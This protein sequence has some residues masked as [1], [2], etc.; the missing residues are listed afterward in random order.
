MAEDQIY[1]RGHMLKTPFVTLLL[2]VSLL[3]QSTPP[4]PPVLVIEEIKQTVAFIYGDSH[5]KNPKTGTIIHIKGAL[6]TGFFVGYQDKSGAAF[7]YVVTAKHVLKDE[8][9]DKYLDSV[10][11]RVN[12]RDR[13][14]VAAYSIP[15]SDSDGNL[16]WFIRQRRSRR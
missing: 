13:N 14:D 15:V 6:G 2:C 10:T 3:A 7:G 8:L 16:L 9:T 12:L 11:L 4:K 1:K 5:I